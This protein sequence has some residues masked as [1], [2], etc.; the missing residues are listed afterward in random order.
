MDPGKISYLARRI[1][2]VSMWGVLVSGLVQ[3][4]TGLAQEYPL[5]SFIPL[6]TAVSVHTVNSTIFV[7]FLLTSMLTG[8]TMYLTPW[9]IKTLTKPQSKN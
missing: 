7:V 3:M 4:L 6:D 8:L 9:L 5:F 2:R 1:H